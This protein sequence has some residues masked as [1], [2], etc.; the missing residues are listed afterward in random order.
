MFST[1]YS[2]AQLPAPRIHGPLFR[3]HQEQT[4]LPHERSP[5]LFLPACF[6]VYNGVVVVV[7]ELLV[8]AAA[9]AESTGTTS[10][11][12]VET[13]APANKLLAMP[14]QQYSYYS[15]CWAL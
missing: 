4:R 9:A 14:P 15:N 12:A 1:D 3:V 8:S 2:S 6:E 7:V 13:A 5:S 11:L 10:S